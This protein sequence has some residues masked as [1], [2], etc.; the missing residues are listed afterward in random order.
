MGVFCQSSTTGKACFWDSKD[1]V[2]GAAIQGPLDTPMVIANLRNGD[3][4][5]ENCTDCHRGENVFLVHP[6]TPLA[7]G[8]SAVS[9]SWYTPNLKPGDLVEPTRV[10]AR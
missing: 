4:L 1:R 8:A 2:T 9:P 3:T 6:G 10:R 5:V 7:F